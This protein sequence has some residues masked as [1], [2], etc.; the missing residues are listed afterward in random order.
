MSYLGH[1]SPGG[2]DFLP[3]RRYMNQLDELSACWLILPRETR[4]LSIGSERQCCDGETC[5]RWTRAPKWL[6][7]WFGITNFA[8]LSVAG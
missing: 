8:Y 1:F 5:R 4:R 3:E 2:I 7:D 6:N